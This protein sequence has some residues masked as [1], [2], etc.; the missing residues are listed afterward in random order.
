ME[1]TTTTT[2]S[3][4]NNASTM[5]RENSLNLDRLISSPQLSNIFL[6]SSSLTPAQQQFRRRLL[7]TLAITLA[8][9]SIHLLIIIGFLSSYNKYAPHEDDEHHP[10]LPGGGGGGTKKEH[11][12]KN[13]DDDDDEDEWTKNRKKLFTYLITLPNLIF[14]FCMSSC[15]FALCLRKMLV[16][17]LYTSHSS[18][19]VFLRTRMA[20]LGLY[21]PDP[22][23]NSMQ[24]DGEQN[25]VA[26]F[27]RLQLAM[28]DRD[29]NDGDYEALLMLDENNP[30]RNRVISD[31]ELSNVLISYKIPNYMATTPKDNTQNDRILMGA[32]NI[33]G[34]TI[35]DIT[36][37]E[38]DEEN[39]TL[40]SPG[41]TSDE[42]EDLCH[43]SN[44][45][46]CTVEEAQRLLE[47]QCVICLEDYKAGDCI[48]HLRT[49]PHEFH[50]ICLSK[51]LKVKAICPICKAQAL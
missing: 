39:K 28:V 33:G 24:S 22:S 4:P 9:I 27:Y 12:K 35:V 6:P 17:Y 18:T 10:I 32:D 30:V 25:E 48:S 51:A 41:S 49:C 20:R 46:Y 43:L 50:T 26:D 31:N 3:R 8:I 15:L 21:I 16:K 7:F 19:A 36:E 23:L 40:L 5:N 2:A 14:L 44:I 1:T 42:I 13:D 37:Y 47:K 11:E 29:F 38:I 45:D 34:E